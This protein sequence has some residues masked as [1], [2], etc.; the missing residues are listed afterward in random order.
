MRGFSKVLVILVCIVGIIAFTVIAHI[1]WALHRF[2]KTVKPYSS[3]TRLINLA[4]GMDDYKQH[5][6]QWPTNLTQLVIVRPDL[7]QDTTDAYGYMVILVNYNEEK[8]CGELIS[9]GKDGKS[10]GDNKYDR[11]IEIRFPMNSETNAQWNKQIS[12][13]F[14]S[15]AD[16]GLPGSW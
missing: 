1:L 9:Y 5:N 13:R 8:G 3:Y 12:E 16:R 4:R 2:D 10:G 11:D 14:K 6:G 15:R 7:E